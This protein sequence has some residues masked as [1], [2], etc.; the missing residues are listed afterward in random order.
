MEIDL[1]IYM[2]INPNPGPSNCLSC[3]YLNS[4]L[5]SNSESSCVLVVGDFNIPALDWTDSSSPVNIGGNVIG[6]NFCDNGRQL[7]ISVRSRSNPYCW[8]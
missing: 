6:D 8:K 5:R 2:D 4:S 7:S 3:L 1:T